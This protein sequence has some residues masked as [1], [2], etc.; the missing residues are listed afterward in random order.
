[1]KEVMKHIYFAL[2]VYLLPPAAHAENARTNISNELRC[3]RNLIRFTEAKANKWQLREHFPL[4]ILYEDGAFYKGLMALPDPR[5][6]D[7]WHFYS[8]TMAVEKDLS[9]E[10]NFY[11]V[12][13]PPKQLLLV[14]HAWSK[15]KIPP[16]KE[17]KNPRFEWEEFALLTEPY[18][19]YIRER[20]VQFEKNRKN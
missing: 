4:D 13:L 2:F 7:R 19:S 10:L 6:R 16:A 18:T 20:F 11:E 15:S 8:E 14:F 9:D 17:E 5:T 12:K 1:M 3:Y